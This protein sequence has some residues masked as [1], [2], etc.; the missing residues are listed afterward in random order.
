MSETDA[1]LKAAVLAEIRAH[2]LVYG[3]NNWQ[4]LRDKYPEIGERKFFRWVKAV[5]EP[6]PDDS[7]RPQR[8]G[9]KFSPERLEAAR[10][11]QDDGVRRA[12]LAATK[13]VP[14]AP[15]PA[16]MMGRGVAAERSIDFLAAVGEIWADAQLLRD[17]AVKRSE[18][19]GEV[20]IKNPMMF[21]RSIGSRI[22]V[23]E[24]ALKVM[25]EI[26]DLRHMQSFYD[27]IVAIIVDEI[28]P[29]HPEIQRRI[30]ERLQALNSRR[31]MTI[32]ADPG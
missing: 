1:V 8:G 25:Q 31:G 4:I 10:A 6:T 29:A 3:P 19:T 12:R 26:W 5:R 28:G 24:T 2:L 18:E 7:K 13:N 11:A 22:E 14:A 20:S 32:F 21:A 27:E 17:H 16:Y 23:M 9:S 15:S 30:L